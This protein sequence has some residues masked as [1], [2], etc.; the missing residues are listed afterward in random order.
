MKADIVVFIAPALCPFIRLAVGPASPS[1]QRSSQVSIGIRS[2]GSRCIFVRVWYV[3]VTSQPMQP[4]V[5]G[6]NQQSKVNLVAGV[7]VKCIFIKFKKGGGERTLD[8]EKRNIGAE[9]AARGEICITHCNAIT[10]KNRGG[11]LPRILASR[12]EQQLCGN[13]KTGSWA[14]L[15]FVRIC[16]IYVRAC[17]VRLYLIGSITH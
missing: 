8:I 4:G 16:K 7:R 9:R 11:I 12:W 17:W 6:S 15:V 5:R 14:W 1:A 3:G 10:T 2:S 13:A